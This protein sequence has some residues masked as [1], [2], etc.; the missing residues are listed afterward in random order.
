MS[1]GMAAVVYD[2]VSERRHA[3]ALARRLREAE[4]LSIAQIADRL[5][6]SPAT[7]KAYF[8]DPTGEKARAVRPAAIV[9]R[10]VTH[11]RAPTWGRGARAP[12]RR[13]MAG[14]QRRQPPLREVGGC[15]RRDPA[16]RRG[17]A[18]PSP[19]SRASA[20][21]ACRDVREPRPR[22][23]DQPEDTESVRDRGDDRP[24]ERAARLCSRPWSPAARLRMVFCLDRR[25]DEAHANR[26]EPW[27]MQS[28]P[29]G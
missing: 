6:R 16:T 9:L 22:G 7:V 12:G 15:P 20:R 19:L 2:R 25:R 11:A 1:S 17:D 27:Q 28:R 21:T 24:T 18:H 14:R 8:Y 23:D 10:L 5:G 29:R 4:G 26:S 13:R 3:V